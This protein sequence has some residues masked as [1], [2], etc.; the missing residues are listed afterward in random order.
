MEVTQ[1]TDNLTCIITTVYLLRS[2]SI[3]FKQLRVPLI[4][5]PACEV[6]R[7]SILC[8]VRGAHS[9]NDPAKDFLEPTSHRSS[10][11]PDINLTL[12]LGCLQRLDIGLVCRKEAVTSE[13]QICGHNCTSVFASS[14]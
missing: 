9:Q 8:D 1:F 4:Q 3:V 10:A 7:G 12:V 5:L 13:I 14:F 2:T 11:F 6:T